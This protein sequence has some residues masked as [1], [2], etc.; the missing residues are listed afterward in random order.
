MVCFGQ[1]SSPLRSVGGLVRYWGI[2]SLSSPDPDMMGEIAF[3][4]WAICLEG[5]SQIPGLWLW[6][7]G[8]GAASG[9]DSFPQREQE[10]GRSAFPISAWDRG[11]LGLVLHTAGSPP[12]VPL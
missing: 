3:V 9:S 10:H 5:F 11:S 2:V 4:N 12:L 8:A 1:G 7:P 6:A